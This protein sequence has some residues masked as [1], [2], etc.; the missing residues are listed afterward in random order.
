MTPRR[1]LPFLASYS[2]ESQ[3]MPI[4]GE[5]GDGYIEL[6]F[7]PRW[8]YIAVVRAFIQSFLAISFSDDSRADKI[9]M[10][11]S[12]LWKTRSSTPR[13]RRPGLG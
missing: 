12:E 3:R 11:A 9:A 1:A 10:A 7:G 8:R 13:A 6:K 4:E 2:K 5:E